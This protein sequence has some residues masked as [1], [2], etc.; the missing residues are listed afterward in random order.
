MEITVLLSVFNGEKW[1]KYSIESILNQSFRDFEFLI[2]NDG[3]IDSTKK[4]LEQYAKDDSRIRLI[5]QSNKGL[6][7]SLNYGIKLAKGKWI[8]RIDCDDIASPERL[9]RQYEFALRTN[10]LLVGC[11]SKLIS[12]SGRF[13]GYNK[14]P[15]SEKTLLKNLKSQKKFFS[16]S[17]AFFQKEIVLKI[18]NYR[19]VMKKSQDYDLWLRISEVARI[20]C[21]NYIGTYVREH[22]ERISLDD[23]GIEQRIY[24]HLA[25]ISHRIRLNNIN[26]KDP[27]ES[28]DKNEVNYFINFTKQELKKRLFIDFYSKI[29]LYKKNI[30]NNGSIKS[31]LKIFNYFKD[32]KSIIFLIKWKIYGDFASESI[33][34][35]WKKLYEIK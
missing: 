33:F 4:I 29:F 15:T 30:L 1:L 16:H 31:F 12:D 20:S 9:K 18:G 22:N 21:L 8:A 11:Q 28:K 5:H 35:K 19:K 2:I 27:L 7:Y 24:A 26:L 14:I 6:T 13:L 32:F 17:S 3:S 23:Y 25:N 34:K 10:S